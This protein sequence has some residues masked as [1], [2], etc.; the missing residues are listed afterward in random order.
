MLKMFNLDL[1]ELS[2]LIRVE[3]FAGLLVNFT[4]ST[5]VYKQFSSQK[6][7]KNKKEWRKK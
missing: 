3:G 7:V 6:F 2:L 5:L 1:A 4:R